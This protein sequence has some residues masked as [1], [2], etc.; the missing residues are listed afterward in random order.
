MVTLSWLLIFAADSAE[1]LRCLRGDPRACVDY[2]HQELSGPSVDVTNAATLLGQA[3]WAG[4][5]G[6]CQEFGVMAREGFGTDKDL[7]AA[8]LAFGLRCSAGDGEGCTA[9]GRLR[10]ATKRYAAALDT[11]RSACER[12]T[13]SSCVQVGRILFF[14]ANTRAAHREG[15]ALLTH[16]CATGEAEACVL[17]GD[18]DAQQ[19]RVWF[20]KACAL[21]SGDGCV[22]LADRLTSVSQRRRAWRRGCNLGSGEAC[23]YAAIQAHDDHHDQEARRFLAASCEN[24]EAYACRL[25]TRR[26]VVARG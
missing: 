24:G 13:Q 8:A 21:G 12:G 5:A 6:A 23:M 25:L 7:L 10:E 17:A 11:Y 26:L 16:A 22:R 18:G 1:A 19:P 14:Y 4:D 9:L 3:C 20:A 2:A 15:W